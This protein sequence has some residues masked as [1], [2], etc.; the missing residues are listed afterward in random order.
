MITSPSTTCPP[1]L[2]LILTMTE[3]TYSRRL[4]QLI[5]Q[6][7]DHPNKDE[8]LELAKQQLEDDTFTINQGRTHA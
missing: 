4:A 8:I 6:M 1:L 5:D 7:R 2:I 3:A